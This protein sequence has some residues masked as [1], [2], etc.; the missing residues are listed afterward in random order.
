[1]LLTPSFAIS[2]VVAATW[3]FVVTVSDV[4]LSS[5]MDSDEV[6]YRRPFA[7][8]FAVDVSLTSPLD[9]RCPPVTLSTTD[10]VHDLLISFSVVRCSTIL[11][12]VAPP[13]CVVL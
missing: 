8:A 3:I 10:V 9:V 4:D 2:C 6:V 12:G 11:I 7:V 13:D 1:M 5:N